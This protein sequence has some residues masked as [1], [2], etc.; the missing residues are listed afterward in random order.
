[1]HLAPRAAGSVPIGIADKAGGMSHRL[2]SLPFDAASRVLLH[3]QDSLLGPVAAPVRGN[4]SP[5]CRGGRCLGYVHA[6]RDGV[7]DTSRR[8]RPWCRCRQFVGTL[9][10][11]PLT[12][13]AQ[14][15]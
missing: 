2:Q 12:G 14:Y 7:Y 4:R 11:S 6:V 8:L 5:H 10:T 1:L 9:R 15:R 3:N 13:S